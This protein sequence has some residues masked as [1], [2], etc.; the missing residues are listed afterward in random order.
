MTAEILPDLSHL[1]NNYRG[2]LLDAYGVFWGGNA[3][4][5]IA[6]AKEM[7]ESLVARD[8]IVGILS[9]TTQIASKEIDKLARHG[10]MQGEHFHFLITSGE[11]A[12]SLFLN[13]QL[14]FE[15]PRHT[16][17]VLGGI[18]PKFAS[19]EPIFN[20]TVYTETSDID[21]ADFIYIS[22]P[23]L[24]G[25]DQTDPNLFREHVKAICEKK[26]PM[27]CPN[28]D[29][30]AHEGT[31]PKAVVRQGSIA[32]LYEEM[33]GQVFYIGKPNQQAYTIALELFRTYDV[34]DQ[35]Q[36]LMIGD[37]PETDIRGARSCGMPSALVTETGMMADRIASKGLKQALTELPPQ[38]FPNF[39]IK[40]F[41]DALHTPS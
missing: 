6:G 29:L 34:D 33:G 32:K 23:H 5:L 11:I 18:H 37:T 31:P 3:V 19:H 27:F 14:P 22:I 16:Y 12:R 28:P 20:G 21:E 35:K 38:D 1:S 25:Q 10:L 15:T 2:F 30:F 39:F 8:K 24:N 9:N 17:W 13:S 4:G 40:R 36:L 41:A 26:L 7:M